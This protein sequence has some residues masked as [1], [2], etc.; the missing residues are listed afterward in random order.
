M[1]QWQC[2]LMGRGFTNRQARVTRFTDRIEKKAGTRGPP[3]FCT[4]AV[5]TAFVDGGLLLQP[6]IRLRLEGC[7]L[8]LQVDYRL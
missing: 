6:A 7:R 5:A 2:T 3:W 4:K 1:K 8:R